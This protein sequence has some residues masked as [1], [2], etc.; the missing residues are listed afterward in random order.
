MHQ[1]NPGADVTGSLIGFKH[2]KSSDS[3]VSNRP[4]FGGNQYSQASKNDLISQFNYYKI[5]SDYKNEVLSANFSV[6]NSGMLAVGENAS[7][8]MKSQDLIL[9]EMTSGQLK[10]SQ[11]PLNHNVLGVTSNRA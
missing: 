6:I 9:N 7:C 2:D 5:I 11:T 4:H 1:R 3:H 8:N 10:G